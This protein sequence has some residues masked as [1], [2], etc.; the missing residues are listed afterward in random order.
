[1]VRVQTT[2]N[3][4]KKKDSIR[5]TDQSPEITIFFKKKRNDK[6]EVKQ[7]R[8]TYEE[9]DGEGRRDSGELGSDIIR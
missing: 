3:E 9:G 7:W 2:K 4:R 1:M 6:N 8:E 5:K